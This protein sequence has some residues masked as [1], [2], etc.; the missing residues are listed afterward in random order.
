[1]T[2][3]KILI[4]GGDLR[5]L[6]CAQSLAGEFSIK[7]TGFDR[8][9]AEAFP[10]FKYAE[11]SENNSF[12]CAVLPIPALNHEGYIHTPFSS[13]ILTAD[14]V[15]E[16][17]SENGKI[18]AG[19]ADDR[20]RRMLPH[21]EITDYVN[22]EDFCLRNA[23]PTA[24]GAVQ[25]A[26]E[27]LPVTLNGSEVLIVGMGRIGCALAEILKGFG[28]NVTAAVHNPRGAA[29]ARL[30]G[31]SP[32]PT[33]RLNGNYRLVFN[34]VPKMIFDREMLS[35]FSPSTLFIDLASHPGGIDIDAASELGI[36]TVTAQGLPGKTSP[37][38]AGEIIGSTIKAMINEGSDDVE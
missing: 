17:L 10:E 38:T 8:T 22:R 5:Q 37:V 23:V 29:K 12:D 19:R 14:A 15:D 31:I 26:L 9:A 33:K 18:F 30:H 35:R 2:K 3:P 7:I 16:F 25:L 21:R 36:K 20:L 34:T 6:Y 4:A 13:E 11:L 24:E 27:E 28:A 32:I 1:M